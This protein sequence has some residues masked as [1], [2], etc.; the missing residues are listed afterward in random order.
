MI[1]LNNGFIENSGQNVLYP[2]EFSNRTIWINS[3]INYKIAHNK[4]IQNT[5]YHNRFT[6]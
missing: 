5:P 6:I 2:P 4:F 3:H 1:I